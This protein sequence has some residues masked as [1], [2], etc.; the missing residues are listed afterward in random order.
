M[1]LYFIF[2]GKQWVDDLKPLKTNWVKE[3]LTTAPYIILVFK[4]IFGYWPDGT[5]RTHYYNELSIAISAGMLLSAIQ[6]SVKPI[7]CIQNFNFEKY[8]FVYY[9]RLV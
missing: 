7:A 6:V 9:P 3:Y 8:N 1:A 5:K 2:K 4:K